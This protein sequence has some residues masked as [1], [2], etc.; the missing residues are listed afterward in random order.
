MPTTG[1][2]SWCE[3]NRQRITIAEFSGR[4]GS[5]ATGP[6]TFDQSVNH[7]STTKNV[8]DLGTCL[9]RGIGCGTV[10]KLT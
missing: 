6:Y 2:S 7:N 10:F 8:G 4:D 3:S 1:Y 9:P 5:E